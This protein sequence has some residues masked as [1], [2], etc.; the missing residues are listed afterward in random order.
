MNLIFKI[1]IINATVLM[2]RTTKALS[3]EKDGNR[4]VKPNAS[5]SHFD[6]AELRRSMPDAAYPH[7]R[8]C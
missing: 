2:K 8:N 5:A 6:S 1:Q 3:Y 4:P 7:F